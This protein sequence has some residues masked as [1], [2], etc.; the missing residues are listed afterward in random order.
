MS[1]DD[2]APEEPKRPGAAKIM[3]DVVK[4]TVSLSDA[5]MPPEERAE[6]EAELLQLSPMARK[7][8]LLRAFRIADPDLREKV[9]LHTESTRVDDVDV[10]SDADAAERDRKR[11]ARREAAEA[12]E[13]APAGPKPASELKPIKALREIVKAAIAYGKAAEGSEEQ[14][15]AG[16]RA[17]ELAPVVA[18]LGLFKAFLIA[19]PQLRKQLATVVEIRRIGETQAA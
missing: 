16:A 18:P 17:I 3:L 14:K 2:I 12:G 9:R 11:R 15:A 7:V 13:E 4:L 8:G 6:A 19:N 10:F 5:D 1:E